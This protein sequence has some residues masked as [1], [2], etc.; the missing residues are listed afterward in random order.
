MNLNDA[1]GPLALAIVAVVAN[2]K[3]TDV[4]LKTILAV[5]A[6]EWKRK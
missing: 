2:G 6:K 5:I 4:P 1:K 3:T